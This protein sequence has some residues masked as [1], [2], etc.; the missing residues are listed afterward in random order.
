MAFGGHELEEKGTIKFYKFKIDNECFP[1][2]QRLCICLDLKFKSYNISLA[3]LSTSLNT[4]S[5]L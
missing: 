3:L 2:C 1:H 4:F 5:A